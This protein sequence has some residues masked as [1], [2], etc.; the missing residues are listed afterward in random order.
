MN[1]TVTAWGEKKKTI[2]VKHTIIISQ[3]CDERFISEDEAHY[4]NGVLNSTIVHDSIH[5]T[6][7]TNGFSL[8]KSKLFLPRYQPNSKLFTNIAALSR[9]ATTIEAFRQEAAK[10]LTVAY[11]ELCKALNE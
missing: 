3:D 11:V 10:K 1:D 9:K 6:F 8:N 5:S 4:I 2:C 7:K